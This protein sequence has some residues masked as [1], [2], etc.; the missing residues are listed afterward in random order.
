MYTT[1]T[2]AEAASLIKNGDSLGLSGFT[3][4]G[5]PKATTKELAKIAQAEHEKRTFHPV[6]LTLFLYLCT[7][8][9]YLRVIYVH[10]NYCC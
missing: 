7:R 8:F 10:N 6:A 1:I 9:E 2:A 4:A 3:P 5:A